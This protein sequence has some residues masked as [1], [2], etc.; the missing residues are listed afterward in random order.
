[1]HNNKTYLEFLLTCLSLRLL[2][3]IGFVG[4]WG[5][6]EQWAAP[7]Q[8]RWEPGMNGLQSIPA[9]APFTSHSDSKAADFPFFIDLR[10]SFRHVLNDAKLSSCVARTTSVAE[11]LGRGHRAR[12]SV[13][14]GQ[15]FGIDSTSRWNFVSVWYLRPCGSCVR[16]I[17]LRDLSIHVRGT[18]FAILLRRVSTLRVVS[19]KASDA[20]YF[21][22]CVGAFY[23]YVIKK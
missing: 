11:L 7:A 1:M 12:L 18:C 22:R 9:T 20:S 2:K 13:H 16:C 5:S 3:V 14:I 23:E 8:R 6:S 15:T 17:H 4:Q 21:R 19:R 10:W